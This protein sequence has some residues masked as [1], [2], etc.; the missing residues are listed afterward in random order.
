MS[1]SLSVYVHN[2]DHLED[3]ERL[4][5]NDPYTQI[6][7]NYE[8]K[9]S[10]QKTATKKNGGKNPEW[11]QNLVL[12]NYDQTK[13]QNLYVEV[14]DEEKG[15]DEPIAFTSIPLRQVLDAPNHVYKGKFDLYNT[16]SK[17]KGTISLTISILQ[18]GQSAGSGAPTAT[19]V[20]GYS[21]IETAHQKR[22]KSA[23][24]KERAADGATLAALAAAGGIASSLLG[25]GAKKPE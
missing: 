17:Q 24:N 11:N 2:A 16:D 20:K 13:H 9:A 1:S 3:V 14:F 12:D 18:P 10:F 8:D 5:K 23:Q 4:G 7:L 19:E 6:T 22:F 21:Q 15:V 25:G